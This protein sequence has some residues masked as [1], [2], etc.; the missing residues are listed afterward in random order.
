MRVV[1]APCVGRCEQAP[2]VVVGQKPIAHARSAD[3]ALAVAAG[4]AFDRAPPA[5]IDAASY[6]AGGGY[7]LLA[8]VLSGRRST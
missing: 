1:E 7:A 5:A 6:R 2:V 4:D 8:D 3:V